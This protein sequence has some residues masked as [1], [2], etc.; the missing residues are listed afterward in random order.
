MLQREI[1]DEAKR[2]LRAARWE[3]D[4]SIPA[5]FG[6]FVALNAFVPS[7]PMN[8]FLLAAVAVLVYCLMSIRTA[9]H[10]CA[11]RNLMAIA[12]HN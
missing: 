6:I 7:A 9:F 12:G 8:Y 4:I 3:R 11:V 5:V 2:D 1:L 10:A